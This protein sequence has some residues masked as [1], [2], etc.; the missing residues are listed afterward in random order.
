[1]PSRFEQSRE[2][3][4]NYYGIEVKR[5]MPIVFDGRPGRITGLDGQYLIVRLEHD[6]FGVGAQRVHPTWRVAYPTLGIEA[7][8]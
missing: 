8:E 5:G 6:A 3:I 1:M 4:R 7:S 2:H